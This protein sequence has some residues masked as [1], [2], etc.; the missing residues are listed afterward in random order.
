[1]SHFSTK[2]V[3]GINTAIGTTEEISYG[4]FDCGTIH[5]PNGSTI[6]TL[7]WWSSPELGGTYEAALKAVDVALSPITYLATV[8]TVAADGAYP[9]PESL[10]GSVGIKAV[11]NAAGDV[12]VSLKSR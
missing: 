10:K 7:T 6:T 11:A 2:Q 5:V 9:I 4:E 12:E 3:V 8:Q 1:M